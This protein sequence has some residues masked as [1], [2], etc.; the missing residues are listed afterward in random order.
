[1]SASEGSDRAAGALSALEEALRQALAAVP[2]GQVVKCITTA[3]PA[4]VVLDRSARLHESKV[5]KVS[6]SM[7]EELADAVRARTGSGGFSRYVTDAVSREFQHDLLGELLDEL[8][9]EYGPVPEELI[10]QARREW[11]DH[12]DQS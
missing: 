12:D 7:P 1:M 8:D 6:V 10:Q 9:A 3:L 2:R 11:P 4:E 5:R